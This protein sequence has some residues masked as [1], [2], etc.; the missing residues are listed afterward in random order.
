MF[1]EPKDLGTGGGVH[2][3]RGGAR[4]ERIGQPA[5]DRDRDCV[6]SAY[7][8]DPDPRPEPSRLLRGRLMLRESMVSY[9]AKAGAGANA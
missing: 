7:L 1:G 6:S 5:S 2:R 8:T 3:H 9:F 4:L